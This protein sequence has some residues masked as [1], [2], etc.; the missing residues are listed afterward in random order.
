MKKFLSFYLSAIL[1]ISGFTGICKAD[2]NTLSTNVAINRP[3]FS[4]AT[5]L[6]NNEDFATDGNINTC[7]YYNYEGRYHVDLGGNTESDL[8]YTIESIRI[9]LPEDY[10]NFKVYLS[11]QRMTD[12]SSKK[13]TNSDLILVHD[14]SESSIERDEK[15]WVNIPADIEEKYRFVCIYHSSSFKINELEVYTKDWVSDEPYYWVEVSAFKPAFA[16][17]LYSE[18]YRV[19]NA[20]DRAA[21]TAF[22]SDTSVKWQNNTDRLSSV[23]G[24]N[25]VYFKDMKQRMIIDLG[26]EYPIHSIVFRPALHPVLSTLNINQTNKYMGGFAV[27][28]T[29]DTSLTKGDTGFDYIWGEGGNIGNYNYHKITDLTGS[30]RYIVVESTAKLYSDDYYYHALGINDMLIYTDSNS[31]VTAPELGIDDGNRVHMISKS[32]PTITGGTNMDAVCS[33]NLTDTDITTV[34][35][36]GGSNGTRYVYVDLGKPQKINYVTAILPNK[37]PTW[38]NKGNIIFVTNTLIDKADSRYDLTRGDMIMHTMSS[39]GMTPGQMELYT[40]S[41]EMQG[42]KFRYVVYA[43]IDKDDDS[44]C[45]DSTQTENAPDVIRMSLSSL[46]VYTKE[47]NLNEVHTDIT[48]AQGSSNL[49]F[50][51]NSDRFFSVTGG[52]YKLIA[53]AYNKEGDFLYAETKEL[54]LGYCKENVLRD[55]ISLTDA[56]DVNRVKIMLWDAK[57]ELRPVVSSK[58]FYLPEFKPG[59]VWMSF[60]VSPEGSDDAL[61]TKEDPF[62]TIGRA[63]TEVRKYNGYMEGDITVNIMPGRY[64]QKEHLEFKPEDSGTNGYNIIWQGTD[65]DNLPTISGAEKITGTW[66]EGE[67]GIWH[68]Q[69]ENLDFAREMFVNDDMA[70][71]ARSSK[72]IYGKDYYNTEDDYLH[73]YHGQQNTKY[74]GFYVDKSKMGLYKNPEDVEI[75]S[76]MKFRTAL[77]HVDDI[78]EDPENENQVIVI[79]DREFWNEYHIN[80]G[81][82]CDFTPSNGF[83]VENA[84]ELLDEPGEFYF[85]K[86]TKTLSYIPREGEDLA[87][88]EILIPQY[89]QLL[90]VNGGNVY[91]RAH[92]IRFSNIR[93]AHTTNFELEEGNVVGSQGEYHFANNTPWFMGRAAVLVDWAKNVDF[94]SCVFYGLTGIGLHHRDGVYNCDVVGNVFADLGAT[95]FCSGTK[96]HDVL[97]DLE[98]TK[99]PRDAAWHAPWSASYHYFSSAYT[100]QALNTQRYDESNKSGGYGWYSEPWAEE[101]G[102]YPWIMIE[103]ESSYSLESFEFSFPKTATEE[104]RSNFEVI[105]SFDRNFGKYEVLKTYT[106]AA[107][108]RETI[109]IAGEEKYRYI[110]LRKTQPGPFC[111]SGVWAWTYD[112]PAKGNIGVPENCTV[113]NNYF[114]RVAQQKQGSYPIWLNWTRGYEVVYNTIDDAPYTGISVGWG[115]DTNTSESAGNNKINYNRI[116]DVMTYMDDGAGI[117]VL[118][119]NRGTEICGNYITN[120]VL[121]GMAIYFDQGST[122]VTASKNVSFGT[123]EAFNLNSLRDV[124]FKGAY[125]GDIDTFD[126]RGVKVTNPYDI[127]NLQYEPIEVFSINN[128]PDEVVGIMADAGIEDE[129]KWILDRVPAENRQRAILHGP[130]ASDSKKPLSVNVAANPYVKEEIAIAQSMLENGTF[131]PLPWHFAPESKAEIEYW[132]DAVERYDSRTDDYRN[133]AHIEEQFGLKAAIR[134]ANDSVYHPTYEEMVT[135]CKEHLMRVKITP[136][137]Q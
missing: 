38:T 76:I 96:Y 23:D 104:Q 120:T 47:K 135:M 136:M 56:E 90:F 80:G 99:G 41:E 86:K 17:T 24:D 134:K 87:T 75:H 110:K 111:L 25:G 39:D 30:Y 82:K 46:D 128:P 26:A 68:I 77:L 118:G 50:T 107:D 94:E 43:I 51:V 36:M 123:N 66:T 11:N 13:F 55:K 18:D 113:S 40:A 129:W 35:Q 115:W 20:N 34:S 42:K 91:N 81:G 125:S 121:D 21:N 22:L 19:Y 127:S 61:G 108:F 132:L 92:N 85:N 71:R 116:N 6:S 32:M 102:T 124:A 9:N 100:H 15:G 131:G 31:G 65:P 5:Y 57:N 2:S 117:Y 54:N 64:V 58:T 8:G 103:L 122:G 74:V 88:A 1:F 98:E 52:N 130:D 133:A 12:H 126:Y 10:K 7:Y 89:E 119:R 114:T 3:G 27:Y 112:R 73:P 84:Y 95:A 14:S 93:F 44:D 79:M 137:K 105:A 106:E 62:K 48:F 59:Q 101:E 72:K 33:E 29:N 63:Q 78:I 83:V 67:D 37:S 69:A 97:I 109:D 53:A 60:Y 45:W 16:T 28:G 49:E 70:I 4:F